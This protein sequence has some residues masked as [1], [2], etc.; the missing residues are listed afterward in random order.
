MY[1]PWVDAAEAEHEYGISPIQTLE[2]N[3]YDAVILAVAH[4]QFK[5]MG[6]EKN[7]RTRQA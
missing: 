1:D 2:D 5:E 6:A 7:S 3:T 4:N